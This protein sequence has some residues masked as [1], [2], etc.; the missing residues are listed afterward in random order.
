MK[1]CFTQYSYLLFGETFFPIYYPFAFFPISIDS[2]YAKEWKQLVI[3]ETKVLSCY[4]KIK[5]IK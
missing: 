4:N 1:A 5:I 3:F 2:G